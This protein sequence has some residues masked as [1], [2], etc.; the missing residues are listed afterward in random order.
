MSGLM[1]INVPL[2]SIITPCYN[3]A[4]FISQ[5]IESVLAQTYQNWEMIIVDDGSTDNSYDIILAYTQQD[6]RIRIYQMEQNTGAAVCRN[7][8]IE[9][10]QGEYLAFLDSD[11]LW[12]PEKLEKQLRFMQENDCDFSFTEYE[13]IDEDGKPLGVKARVIKR[14]TYKKMLL[15]DFTGCLT[16][17][18]KR[19]KIFIPKVGNSIEDY[20]LFLAILKHTDKAL[21]YPECLAQYRIHAKS[22]SGNKLNKI[23]KIKLF[24][25]V[26]INIE[27]KN[28][29]LACFYLFTN[30]LIK[31]FWKYKKNK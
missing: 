27:H 20:T 23:K 3:S 2:I 28:I 25:D 8:A 1:S 7:K 19:N 31:V 15:H 13:H 16:V 29:L 30:Q 21:G 24:F 26:M 10:S 4:P 5:T 18:Y 17:M 11:D 9:L 12:I 6:T 22:L 14:L